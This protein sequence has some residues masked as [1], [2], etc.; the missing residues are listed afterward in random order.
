MN[1]GTIDGDRVHPK[2]VQSLGRF[3][4]DVIG[5]IIPLQGVTQGQTED[6]VR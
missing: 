1:Q 2:N 5:I 6:F 4:D 3:G